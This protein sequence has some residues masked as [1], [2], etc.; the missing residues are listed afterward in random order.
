MGD[1]GK[2]H[3]SGEGTILF[4]REYGAP[5]TLT[6]VKY[7]PSLKKNLVSIAM[8]E[9]KGYDVV[10]SKG[11]VFLRHIGTG[12]TKRIGIQ[13]NNLYK[14]EVDDSSTTKERYYAI[15]ID[16]FSRRCSIYFIQK[17]DHTFLRFCEFKAMAEKESG[18]EIKASHSDNGG[19][20]VSQ[21]FKDFYAA[22]GI[23]QELMAPHNP[24]QNG[25]AKR[26]NR[27]IVGVA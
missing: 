14:L 18:K 17:K 2:Y 23:K 6:D 15:F 25:V 5:L 7:V 4:Q 1:D 9:D 24:Q 19:E 12:Q 22:E 11:K 16:D 21:Q 27:S 13:V 3:V 10:F 26:K 8:P 20:Y